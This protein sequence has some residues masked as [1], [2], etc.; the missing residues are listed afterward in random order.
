[1]I[2]KL[3]Y[4]SI[5][6]NEQAEHAIVFI[7][8]WKGNKDSFLSIANVIQIPNAN[9]YFPQA[10]YTIESEN[11]FTLSYQREDQTWEYKEPMML[12]S[13]FLES[14]IFTKYEPE[15]I[16]FIGFSQGATVCYEFILQ[17][18][19]RWGGVFPV[20]G[21]I[22][23]TEAG[24][25]NKRCISIHENQIDTPIIIGHGASDDVV[26]LKSSE[27]IYKAL[28]AAKYNVSF[29]KYNGGHKISLNFLKKIENIIINRM[30]CK[31]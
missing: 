28:L 9:W 12:I 26:P 19:Y 4:N 18:P 14:V 27:L 6:N 2:K 22:R 23:D 24:N 13:N 5:I 7:H 20:A 25:N 3:E 16:F 30:N 15:N 10:P 29:E 11:S 21:F 1:M 31:L 17:L 8:G